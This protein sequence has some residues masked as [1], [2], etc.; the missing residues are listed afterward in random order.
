MD[1]NFYFQFSR[2]KLYWNQAN[3]LVGGGAQPQFNANVLTKLIVPCLEISEQQAIAKILS[4]LDSKIELN[5]Q[6]NKTL[7]A[8]GQAI[9]KRWFIDFEFPNEKGKPYKSSGGEMVDS[10]LG[11]IPKGWKVEK[12]I[13]FFK[14]E[15]G[16]HLPSWDRKEGKIPVFGSGGLSGYHNEGFVKGAGII[17]GRAGKIGSDSIYYSHKD[18]CPLETAFY[19]STNN[20]L[21]IRYLYFFIKTMSM[22][23]TGSSVPNLSR[24]LIHDYK[25]IIP[26]LNIIKRF[27][28]TVEKLFDMKYRNEEEI[29][30]LSQIRDS[31]LP[32]LM[33]GKIR[34]PVEA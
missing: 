12:A 8:I 17:I 19:V 31:L 14:L 3:N 28:I 29:K 2:S 33:S 32:R 25:I 21:L 15:Y 30:N 9:F 6:V 13:N 23:N 10:E 5:Q 16:W 26:D 18:F 11:E 1:N 27:D 4:D 22:V 24:N 7:E 20:K 34:V